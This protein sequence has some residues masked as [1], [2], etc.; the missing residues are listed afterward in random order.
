MRKVT[1]IAAKAPMIAALQDKGDPTLPSVG[2]TIVVSVMKTLLRREFSFRKPRALPQIL[3]KRSTALPLS[4]SIAGAAFD[5][6]Q[7]IDGRNCL[8]SNLVRGLSGM[9]S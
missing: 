7:D 9:P 2:T 6:V 3:R 4:S 8:P 1:A 5:C